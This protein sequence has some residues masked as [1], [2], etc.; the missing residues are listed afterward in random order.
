MA[1]LTLKLKE[2]IN[3]GP[4]ETHV[5]ETQDGNKFSFSAGKEAF[6]WTILT[7]ESPLLQVCKIKILNKYIEQGM[8]QH[9]YAGGWKEAISVLEINY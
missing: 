7:A 6:T 9:E 3:P 2:V 5:Y 8:K 1:K 4:K